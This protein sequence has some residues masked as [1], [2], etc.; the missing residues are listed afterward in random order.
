MNK[1]K[2]FFIAIVLLAVVFAVLAGVKANQIVMMIESGEQFVPPPPIS[3]LH[4]CPEKSPMQLHTPFSSQ[5][6]FSH[7]FWQVFTFLKQD[8]NEK[9]IDA[10]TIIIIR[11]FIQFFILMI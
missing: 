2:A 3:T 5:Y 6:P 11:Y 9:V 7:L 1:I 4:H 8:C 10:K